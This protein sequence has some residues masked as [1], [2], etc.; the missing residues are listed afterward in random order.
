MKKVGLL[1]PLLLGI[2]T[3]CV[4]TSET[5]QYNFSFSSIGDGGIAYA[6][7]ENGTYQDQ[8]SITFSGEITDEKGVFEGYYLGD[9]LLC[10]QLDYELV[11]N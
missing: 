8:T 5:K 11:L 7:H 4:T 9:T 2:L 10:D 6:D 1:I 3:G